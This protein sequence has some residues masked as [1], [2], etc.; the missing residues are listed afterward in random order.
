MQGHSAHYFIQIMGEALRFDPRVSLATT[1]EITA[2]AAGSNYSFDHSAIREVVKY[3]ERLLADHKSMLTEPEAFA[4]VMSLLNIYVRS[5]WPEALD[6]LW[7][8]DEIF[9]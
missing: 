9:R 6:L 5:G 3:T 7:K 8:L 1:S 4:Q 2:I